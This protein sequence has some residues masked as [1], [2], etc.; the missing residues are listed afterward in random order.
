MAS[1]RNLFKP[2]R[3]KVVREIIGR[4][5]TVALDKFWVGPFK[6]IDETVPN[7]E[8][9]DKLRNGEARGYELSGLLVNAATEA[10]TAWIMRDEGPTASLEEEDEYTDEL[11]M[12]L[13][14]RIKSQ[15]A[16]LINDVQA[17]GDQYV[18]VNADG[19]LSIPSPDI[20]K[21]E[22]DP[23]DYRRPTAYII[24]TKMDKVDVWDEYRISGRTIRIKNKTNEMLETD[25]GAIQPGQTLV[26]EFPNLIGRLPVVHFAHNRSSNETN[27]KPFAAPVRYLLSWYDDLLLKALKGANRLSNPILAMVNLVDPEEAFHQNSAETGESYVDEDGTIRQREQ[28]EID[29][30]TPVLFTGE[31]GDVKF[32]SPP[33]GF[34][35]DIRNL[36]KSLY[37]LFIENKG[38]PDVIMGFEMSAARA[39]AVEQI[40]T[41]FARIEHKRAMLEG[42]GADEKLGVEAQDGLLAVIDI[43][44]RYRSL[45]DRRVKVR[46]AVMH[47]PELSEAD[48]ALTLEWSKVLHDRG[49]IRDETLVEMSGRIDDPAEE[50]ELA[51]EESEERQ[52]LIER[53]EEADEDLFVEED[54]AA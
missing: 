15:I 41:F 1:I 24:H 53:D 16:M 30:E 34:T 54:E 19:S 49:T 39:S 27:G 28:V 42:Q 44:L 46:P 25:F 20:V 37:L 31:G 50:V 43:W 38:L 12:R 17:L 52:S 23:L 7:Y 22:R 40:K 33:R 47:W 11:L 45:T 10:F 51:R 18:V 14:R 2:R 3:M 9:W 36:L 5:V 29:S 4:V 35:D 21:V 32:V 6:S 48:E 26:A 13:M 8:F